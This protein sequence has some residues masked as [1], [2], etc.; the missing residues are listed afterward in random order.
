V[1]YERGRPGKNK[2]CGDAFVGTAI[3]ELSLMGI[4]ESD[5]ISLG[6]HRFQSMDLYDGDAL[7]WRVSGKSGRGF[8]LRRANIDQH[9]RDRVSSKVEIRYTSDVVQ[10]KPDEPDGILVQVKSP[11]ETV[12]IRFDSVVIASG[13]ANRLSRKFDICGRPI[14]ATSVMTY[15]DN[16]HP[17][18][19][20]FQ[21]HDSC[22][23][24]YRWIFPTNDGRA[25][26]GACILSAKTGPQTRGAVTDYLTKLDIISHSILAGARGP[27]WSGHKGL[28]HHRAGIVSCGDA[29]GLVD[30]LNGEG[31]T[32]AL[33]SGRQAGMAVAQYLCNRLDPLALEQ[34]S[35][36]VYRY[37]TD[38]YY[39]TTLR[40]LWADLYGK[41]KLSPN[42]E[43]S[44]C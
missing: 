41:T 43:S 1:V 10:L 7:I 38:R 28:R 36:W 40:Q 5:L 17:D 27:L 24:G 44:E 12:T 33:I 34:Y 13:A 16:C 11:D 35:K 31:I 18:V 26:I 37:F 32:A 3:H 15:A 20:L 6:G 2:V 21:F 9:I 8:I 4:T 29:A 42:I 19:P 25:N 14:M 22:V 23:P 30:P 39:P